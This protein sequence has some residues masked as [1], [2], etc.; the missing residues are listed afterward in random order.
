MTSEITIRQIKKN[1][2]DPDPEPRWFLITNVNI[3]RRSKNKIIHFDYPNSQKKHPVLITAVTSALPGKR[4]LC[5]VRSASRATT[6]DH[7]EHSRCRHSCVLNKNG[8][9]DDKWMWSVPTDQCNQTSFSCE[10]PFD[11]YIF[12]Y[13]EPSSFGSPL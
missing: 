3:V 7:Y 5:H 13:L 1:V 2:T 12:D 4:Y 9:I 6:I 10:E 8:W 11:S